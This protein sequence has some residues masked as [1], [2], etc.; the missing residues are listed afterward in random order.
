M[1]ACTAVGT[2]RTYARIATEKGFSYESWK[3]AV[4]RRETFVTYGPLL[5][6]SVDGRPMGSEFHLPASGGTVDVEWQVASVTVPMSRVD[7]MVN[8]EIRESVA[9]SS[10]AAG[11]HWTVRVD[12]SCWLALE[13]AH[14]TLH[15]RLHQRGCYHDHT[16]PLDGNRRL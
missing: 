7:L 13:S 16:P 15:N 9:V 3:E 1:A 10:Q 8:G 4:R 14:R 6:F 12:R 2:V 11:G 5:E